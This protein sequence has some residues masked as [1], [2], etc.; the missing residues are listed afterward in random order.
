M[1][2]WAHR[3]EK[4]PSSKEALLLAHCT[5][6]PSP[7]SCILC[8]NERS[9]NCVRVRQTEDVPHPLPPAG[10]LGTEQDWN[11]AA[12]TR[13]V[14]YVRPSARRTVKPS[15]QRTY[16]DSEERHVTSCGDVIT[17]VGAGNLI[18]SRDTIRTSS[19]APT[20]TGCG[21]CLPHEEFHRLRAKGAGW[22]CSGFE[23][24]HFAV[25]EA[26]GAENRY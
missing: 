22:D 25:A 26:V 15:R 8:E 24:P 16:P 12:I 21:S 2:V 9:K 23:G 7:P 1:Q 18:N 4:A 3:T 19:Q 14:T 6:S 11:K 10:Q 17:S 5:A 13:A 20:R